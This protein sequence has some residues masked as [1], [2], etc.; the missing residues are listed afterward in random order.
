MVT[1]TL[2]KKTFTWGGSHLFRGSVPYHECFQAFVMLAA[3]WLLGNRKSA[4]SV[5]G[6]LSIGN[7]KARPTVT[8]PP[9]RPYPFQQSHSP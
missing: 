9:R 8:L 6:I 7:L 2:I 4:H 5:A 3:S 1:A